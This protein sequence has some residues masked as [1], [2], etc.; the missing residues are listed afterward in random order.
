MANENEQNNDAAAVQANRRAMLKE[1]FSKIAEPVSE[2]MLKI[3]A[4]SINHKEELQ[5]IATD[6]NLNEMVS[7]GDFSSPKFSEE[8]KNDAKDLE[9]Q[10]AL[11][12]EKM[13]NLS[14]MP[15]EER[16]LASLEIGDRI[17]QKAVSDPE[18]NSK[19]KNASK[20]TFAQDFDID[21]PENKDGVKNLANIAAAGIEMADETIQ[22][23]AIE[24]QMKADQNRNVKVGIDIE[25][26]RARAAQKAEGSNGPKQDSSKSMGM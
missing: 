2:A 15:P 26:Y 6:K 16:T 22:K 12:D 7:K 8:F 25:G 11:L 14:D 18:I 5:Q 17:R 21:S 3:T 13:K 23:A 4:F 9:K 1:K 20:K 24:A 10:S 19:L